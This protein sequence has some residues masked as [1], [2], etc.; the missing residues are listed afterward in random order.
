MKYC[1]RCAIFSEPPFS[2]RGRN[3][4]Q[5]FHT[6]LC[7][8]NPSHVRRCVRGQEPLQRFLD[9]LAACFAFP[10]RRDS[11][12]FLRRSN[13]PRETNLAV[14]HPLHGRRKGVRAS[15][16]YA[17]AMRTDV[18]RGRGSCVDFRVYFSSH[19]FNFLK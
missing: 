4:T 17:P 1:K 3:R 12:S 8:R 13:R 2:L 9:S 6:N 7:A 19:R 16:H 18:Q 15:C 11:R 5:S 14:S 10:G